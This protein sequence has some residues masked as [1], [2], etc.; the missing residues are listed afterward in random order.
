MSQALGWTARIWTHLPTYNLSEENY[1]LPPDKAVLCYCYHSFQH[2]YNFTYQSKC[3]SP[4][5][6]LN[7]Y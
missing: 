4:F 1:T 7:K 6:W 5:L 3:I 2:K